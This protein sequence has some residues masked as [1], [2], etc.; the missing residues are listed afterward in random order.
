MTQSAFNRRRS[1]PT[2]RCG[3]KRPEKT[4]VLIVCEGKETEKNYFDQ[5][6]RNEWTKRHFAIKVKPGQGGSR[7]QIAQ[8]A[9]DRKNDANADYDQVWCVMDVEKPEGLDD[10]RKALAILKDNEILSALSNPAFEVWF[11]AHFERTGTGFLH[12]DAVVNRLNGHWRRRFSAD[13]DKSD[14]HI[15]RRLADLMDQAIE[16]ARWVRENHHGRKDVIESN[17]STEVD[18]LV[19]MLHGK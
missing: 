19:G 13:Y 12:G 1:G 3:P 15:Y 16:N 8:L 11:L 2:R 7:Q 17:S 6:K 5:L 14:A 4:T 9:V 18:L 10:M